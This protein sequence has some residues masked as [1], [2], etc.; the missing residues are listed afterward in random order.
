MKENLLN[1]LRQYEAQLDCEGDLEG[2]ILDWDS[3]YTDE[4]IYTTLC[5]ELGIGQDPLLHIFVESKDDYLTCMVCG[6]GA[7]SHD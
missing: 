6:Q 2:Y 1:H 7:Y 3:E 5:Q 4:E